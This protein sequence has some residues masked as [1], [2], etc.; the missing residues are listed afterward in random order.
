MLKVLSLAT[1]AW[2]LTTA[3]A[4][5]GPTL[6]STAYAAGDAQPVSASVAAT[7]ITGTGP[8][9]VPVTLA[10]TLPVAADGSVTPTCDLTSLT[11]PGQ[12]SMVLTVNTLK[13]CTGGPAAFVCDS[14]GT[15]STDPF[16]L[17][18][19]KGVATKPTAKLVP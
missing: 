6:T 5:A 11:S 19:R 9:P 1:L 8:A 12:Y 14:G 17:A 15:A 3:A 2:L 7:A 13:G 18:L 4:V 16:T 10:C